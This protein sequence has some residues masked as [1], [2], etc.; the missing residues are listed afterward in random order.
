MQGLLWQADPK[1]S[2]SKLPEKNFAPWL[3]LP[4]LWG[5]FSHHSPDNEMAHP[6]I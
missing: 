2:S 6:E 5:F 4:E 3:C 1:R